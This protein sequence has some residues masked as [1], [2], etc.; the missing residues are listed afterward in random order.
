MATRMSPARQR[1]GVSEGIAL[2]LCM[3]G[4][5]EFVFEKMRIDLAFEHAWR[6]WPSLYRA[7]YPQVDADL[8]NGTDA[9]WVMTQADERKQVAPFFWD[10]S[11]GKLTIYQR[12][13]DWDSDDSNDVEYALGMIAGDIPLDGWLSLATE[14]LASFDET[15]G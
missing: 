9:V 2:G 3:Q 7:L 15:Y 14:F 10:W 13:D 6:T 11:G 8:R 5:Y 4:R 1:N 12:G